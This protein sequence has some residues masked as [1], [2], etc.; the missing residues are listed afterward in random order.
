LL[1]SLKYAQQDSQKP[2]IDI[3]IFENE[4][5]LSK[6]KIEETLKTEC[7]S[8]V[9]PTGAYTKRAKEKL[10]SLGYSSARSSDIGFNNVNKIDFYALKVQT[11]N[12]STKAEDANKWID[13]AKK[14]GYW[15]IECIHLIGKEENSC[16]YQYFT[17]AKEFEKH[18]YYM[19]NNNNCFLNSQK[20]IIKHI[21]KYF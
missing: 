11:W 10:F 8:F 21:E 2:C 13:I 19:M 3:R 15:L 4:A 9:Y 7:L 16:D 5:L 12:K 20:N 1:R 18:L 14:N 17:N 6:K